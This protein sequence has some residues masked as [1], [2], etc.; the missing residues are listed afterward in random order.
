MPTLLCVNTHYTEYG[1]AAL[2]DIKTSTKTDAL[3]ADPSKTVFVVEDQKIAQQLSRDPK[4]RVWLN[5]RS[6]TQSVKNKTLL[7]S[8]A[9][10]LI[11]E[12]D[13]DRLEK[14][15]VAKRGLFSASPVD[16]LSFLSSWYD[17]RQRILV[18]IYDGVISKNLIDS[19]AFDP[20]LAENHRVIIWGDRLKEQYYQ[21]R[22][23]SK[24]IEVAPHQTLTIF[25]WEINIQNFV[26]DMIPT[27]SIFMKHMR[28]I[29]TKKKYFLGGIRLIL[30]W[31]GHIHPLR[32]LVQNII[33][34]HP[35]H[36][37]LR[38]LISVE[39]PDL[40][41]CGTM[42]AMEEV[43]LTRLAKQRGIKT[44]GMVKSWDNITSK[45]VL[46][47]FPD[48]LI[49]NTTIV[50]EEAIKYLNYPGNRIDVVG[51]PQLDRYHDPNLQETREVFCK[52]TGLHPKKPFILFCAAGLWMSPNEPK[53]LLELDKAIE[54]GKLDKIQILV[55]VHP[56]YD[57]G[58]E[59]LK[60]CKHI[61][62]ER[63]GTY[64]VPALQ[65]WEYE[66]Q[67]LRH[68]ISSLRFAAT[69]LNTASTMAIEAA[70]FDRPIILL[71]YDPIPQPYWISIARYYEREHMAPLIKTGGA[72]L[73]TSFEELCEAIRQDI[74]HPEA[75]QTGRTRI[76][77]EQCLDRNSQSASRL[78]HALLRYLRPSTPAI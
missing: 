50:K 26:W 68:L 78:A 7:G 13:R 41:F 72:R 1:S 59:Q 6:F 70:Y 45:L 65:R 27:R 9:G 61:I 11:Q 71:A 23:G 18:T 39:R 52:R 75:N 5:T 10:L 77:T 63:P 19:G 48:H 62:I 54:E 4:R 2:W 31:I 37:H 20:L 32:W 22:Y 25:P 60:G 40:V 64:I 57:C 49:V 74:A 47:V 73:V 12:D 76:V 35:I 55:R 34:M 43:D 69:T 21:N 36:L 28:R 14:M 51:M 29:A 67:D 46:P 33:L 17:N 66:D 16:F 3:L 15:G 8:L 44:V 24:G 42:V 30:W 56:K 38:S 58:A 53:I